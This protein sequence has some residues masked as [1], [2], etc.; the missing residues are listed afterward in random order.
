MLVGKT[1]LKVL[2]SDA[3]DDDVMAVVR[4]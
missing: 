3:A 2:L 4:D 1:S